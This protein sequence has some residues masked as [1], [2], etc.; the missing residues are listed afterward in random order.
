MIARSEKKKQNEAVLRD[1]LLVAVSWYLANLL[2][3]NFDIPPDSVAVMTRLIP[4]L[5]GT[6]MVPILGDILDQGQLGRAL[7][8]H[9]PQVV[10]HAAAYKHV[11]MMEL[12]GESG[13]FGSG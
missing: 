9:Q 4:L 8:D 10:F 1:F 2:R 13:F 6:E 7:C 12:H 11:L 5:L 3:F